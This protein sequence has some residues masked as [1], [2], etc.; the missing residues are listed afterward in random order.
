MGEIYTTG[1]WK[2][3]TGEEEE[4]VA[5]WSD[6]AQWASESPGAGVLRLARD[7]ADPGR[8][9][10]FGRWDSPEDAHAWKS[11]PEFWERLGRVQAH[12]AE[13]TPD[14]LEIIAARGSD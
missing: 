1:T 12:V 2:P 7:L 8:F 5:A 9:V 14:E 13:F 3:K 10:S 11:S 4:F 6:F